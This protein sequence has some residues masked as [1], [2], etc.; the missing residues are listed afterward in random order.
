MEHRTYIKLPNTFPHNEYFVERQHLKLKD[1]RAAA[2]DFNERNRRAKNSKPSIR[3]YIFKENVPPYP[4]PEFHVSHLKHDTDQVGLEGIKKDGGFKDPG[5]HQGP[6]SLQWWSLAVRPE[7]IASAE[8]RLLEET[9]PDWTEEQAQMQQSFLGRFASSP[10][11][12]ETSRWGSYR[13]TLPVEEVLEAYREQ[14]CF[15]AQP[16]MRVFETV[17]YK[18][19]VMYVVLVHSPASQKYQDYPLLSDDP[20]AVCVYRDGRFIWR[21]QA[22][23]ETHSYQVLKRPDENQMET[24]QLFGNE[25]EFYVWDEVAIALHMEEGQVLK[26]DDVKLRKYLKICNP[27]NPTLTDNFSAAE[28]LVGRLWPDYPGPLE[29]ERSLQESLAASPKTEPD[30]S[31]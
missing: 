18:Q 4:Q 24:E 7:D 17:L 25:V 5:R 19:R 3:R 13:F 29:K 8:T 30:C 15:G 6:D 26:F 21:S 27:G 23:C 11:F 22:M 14:F 20:D 2:E 16:V 31:D 28:S 1:L 12:L 9:Y 10:A